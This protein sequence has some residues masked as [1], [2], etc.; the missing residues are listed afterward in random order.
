M[1]QR[2]KVAVT[3]LGVVSPLG[4]GHQRFWSEACKGKSGIAPIQAFDTTPFRV[5]I[6]G[7]VKDFDSRDHLSARECSLGR[8][9]Q[10]ALA[11]AR[12]ALED[13]GLSGG[14]Y[15]PEACAV[16][17]GTTMGEIQ[18]E[19]RLSSVWVREGPAAVPPS[20]FLSYPV[21][22][23][24]ANLS[25]GL[26]WLGPSLVLPTACAGGNYAI[27]CAAGLVAR[28]EAELALAGGV[29]PMSRVAFTG[30]SRLLSLAPD[31][32]QPFD[33]QRKGLV[34]SEGAGFLALEPLSRARERGAGVY[35]L[36]LG[37]GLGMDA[38][39]M[40]TSHPEG[41][42][43]ARAMAM[44]L[45]SA[46]LQPRHID[47]ISAHGTGTPVN[48]RA[49][50]LAVKRVFG[51]HA[52]RIPMSS[53]KSMIGH[54]MGAASAIEAAACALSIATGVLP[55]TI[56]LRE[57]DPECDLDYV[58]N[59]SRRARVRVALSNAFAFGGNTSAL[60]L[61]WPPDGEGE[62]T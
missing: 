19:E 23:I 45:K 42:G 41:E 36:V 14:E 10:F 28:G 31:M 32:C 35:C 5:K 20:L 46:G 56:N 6:G 22:V 34:V 27:G 12:M 57:P 7:E 8:A 38:Y 60:V 48:D 9:S 39:H 17:V 47:Y 58:P 50:T 61:G 18:V 2:R 30:F 3:G 15:P 16:C 11:A 52:R 24:A 43:A 62:G 44:A 53:I 4:C 40:T 51:E 33:R 29:D 59:A 1:A 55:P 26:N 49:E 54:T 25:R 13:A 21:E 37:Y